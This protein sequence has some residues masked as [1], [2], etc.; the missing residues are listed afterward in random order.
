MYLYIG[1]V[2]ISAR[3]I[4][5]PVAVKRNK[6]TKRYNPKLHQSLVEIVHEGI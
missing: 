5:S 6:T 2:A 4:L 3:T 1:P